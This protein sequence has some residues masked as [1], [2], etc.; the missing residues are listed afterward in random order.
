M[1]DIQEG[2]WTEHLPG[3]DQHHWT[4]SDSD[5]FVILT[6]TSVLIAFAVSSCWTALYVF[7]RLLL[8]S[9]LAPL[10]RLRNFFEIAPSSIFVTLTEVFLRKRR[11]LD[12]WWRLVLLWAVSGVFVLAT[13]GIPVG[14]TWG[15]TYGT[16]ETPKVRAS[17]STCTFLIGGLTP[18]LTTL[19]D[20][21]LTLAASEYFQSCYARQTPLSCHSNLAQDSLEWSDGDASC[22]FAADICVNTGADANVRMETPFLTMDQLGITAPTSLQ[23]KKAMTCSVVRTQSFL[24]VTPADLEAVNFTLA[25]GS[26]ASFEFDVRNLSM[27][28]P[29]Y[30]LTTIPQHV[31]EP[32]SLDSRLRVS[33]GFVTVVLLQAPGVY[34]PQPLDDLMFSAHQEHLFATSGLR[35]SADNL[36]GAAA[37]VDQYLVCNNRTGACSP[38]FSPEEVTVLSSPGLLESGADQRTWNIV[39]TVISLT[40]VHYTIDGR[41]A[42]ALVAQRSLVSQTMQTM[43]ANPW[44]DELS[45]WFGISLAKLQLKIF[46]IAHRTNYLPPE[47]FEEFPPDADTLQLC[48]MITSREGSYTNIHWPGFIATIVLCGVLGLISQI[49]QLWKVRSLLSQTDQTSLPNSTS[50]ISTHSQSI[51]TSSPQIALTPVS[52]QTHASQISILLTQPGL[53]PP[54][55]QSL[56]PNTP[57]RLA[58]SASS[59]APQSPGQPGNS[60]SVSSPAA[61]LQPAAALQASQ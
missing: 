23:L 16:E 2:I 14:A 26:T 39:Q 35:W 53:N 28:A 9:R 27:V 44:R 15:L 60:P 38:W 30:R 12:R 56:P 8:P 36:V 54:T 46:A 13:L 42:S 51:G 34:Y 40:S 3:G 6:L 20:V 31:L 1:S 25:F 19:R 47:L 57:P 33:D 21:N 22:P 52:S 7:L 41:G 32:D 29:G 24:S 61:P 43:S 59:V 48:K 49:F 37:C 55:T 50:H 4:V 5:A 10:D 45:T 18:A 11:A 17:G 58:A